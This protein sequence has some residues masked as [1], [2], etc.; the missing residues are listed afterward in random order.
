MLTLWT[1]KPGSG[2][3]LNLLF[4]LQKERQKEIKETG[5]ARPIFY[6]GIPELTLEGWT[7]FEDPQRWSELPAGAKLVV[8]EAQ[9]FFPVRQK[10]DAPQYVTELS[11][12]RHLGIDIYFITQDPMLVDVWLRRLVNRHILVVRPFGAKMSFLYEW[13]EVTDIKDP[14]KRKQALQRRRRFPKEMYSVYKSAD[15]H[16][17]VV[18]FPWH[19]VAIVI[20]CIVLAIGLSISFV[21]RLL[22]WADSDTTEV[23]Q[24]AQLVAEAARETRQASEQLTAAVR[25]LQ[26]LAEAFKPQI[27]GL[28]WSSPFYASFVEPQVMPYVSGCSR[29]Q[30][31]RIDNCTCTDQQGTVIE[32][33]RQQCRNIVENGNFEWSGQREADNAKLI[34]ALEARKGGA[35]ST[36]GTS[37][38]GTS[39]GGSTIPDLQ[40]PF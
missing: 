26:S 40:T 4:E 37:S 31:G 15:M 25:D 13:T 18:K 5:N 23:E 32:M 29:V 34:A 17:Q 19:K 10:G 30:V 22:S 35:G 24:S 20:G 33:D 36:G 3:T 12:H 14:G 28:P 39:T 38:T 16:T 7:H 8:D 2:K 1:G 21:F 27:E 11:T 9:K 6:N